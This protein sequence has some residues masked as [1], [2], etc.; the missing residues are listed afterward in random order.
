MILDSGGV[1]TDVQAKLRER[2]S[3]KD[4]GA[5]GDGVTDDTAALQA[6]L[7]SNTVCHMPAGKYRTTSEL[8]IDPV[9]NRNCGFISDAAWSWYPYTRQESITWDGTK[10][11]IIY[12]DGAVDATL[13]VIRASAEAVGNEPASLFYNN[14]YGLRLENVLLDGNAKAGFGFYSVRLMGPLVNNCS[15]RGTTKH[16]WYINGNYSGHFN[17]I[18]AY[19]NAGCGISVGRAG[20]DYSWTVNN[21]INATIFDNLH[22]FANGSDKAFDESSNPI[23]GYGVGMWLHRGNKIGHVT[24]EVNDGVGIYLSPSSSNNIIESGYTELNNV[25]A[26]GGL[27]TDAVSEGRA[28][29]QWGVWFAGQ[30]G[31]VSQDTV[32]ENMF[33]ASE[34]V[35]LLGTEPG[36]GRPE[37]G[38][39]LKNITGADYLTSSW[40]NFRLVNCG[41]EIVAALAGTAPTGSQ[42]FIGGIQIGDN[43]SKLEVYEE[44]TFTPTVYGSTTTGAQVYAVQVGQWQKV[45]NMI[46][47]QGYVVLSNS[48]G[49][50]AGT[51]RIGGIPAAATIANY[52][53]A[54]SIPYWHDLGSIN[55]AGGTIGSGNAYIDL[56]TQAA[57]SSAATVNATNIESTTRFRFAATYRV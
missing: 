55:V 10:E 29:R 57:G 7:D 8:I 35:K 30:A 24:T 38:L 5:V 18:S 21:L 26:S 41:S 50:E 31:G 32:I 6:A 40:A 27:G 14:V 4:F 22:C 46:H 12:Y 2:V 9:R 36:V 33:L 17:G 13:A 11:A 56:H 43:S 3:V 44:G 20:I 39:E 1:T 23:W 25:W 42:Q 52:F 37:S 16:A 15:V 53:A 48:D 34:G 54:V 45:G 51:L 19:F 28:T 47:I 49:N